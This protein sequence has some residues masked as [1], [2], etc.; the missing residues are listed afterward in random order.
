MTRISQIA[1]LPELAR[2]AV[3][4]SPDPAWHRSRP[5]AAPAPHGADMA[6]PPVHTDGAAR[7]TTSWG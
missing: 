2:I 7:R 5:V 6:Q 4:G 3:T 1:P